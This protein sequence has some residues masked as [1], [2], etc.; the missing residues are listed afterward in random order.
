VKPLL[1]GLLYAWSM[2]KAADIPVLSIDSSVIR[3]YIIRKPE[4]DR[5]YSDC[6][7]QDASMRRGERRASMPRLVYCTHSLIGG[8]D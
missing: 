8:G 6:P 4:N 5:R 3:Q 7:R 1:A 2:M